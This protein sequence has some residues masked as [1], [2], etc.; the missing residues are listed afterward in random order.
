MGKS[1]SG[2][3]LTSGRDGAGSILFK[4]DDPKTMGLIDRKSASYN[5]LERLYGNTKKVIQSLKRSCGIKKS[6]DALSFLE[7]KINLINEDVI[8]LEDKLKNKF[9]GKVAK[10]QDFEACLKEALS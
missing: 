5:M 8:V 7:S 6:K 10:M 9:D 3:L 1:K 2:G 4:I